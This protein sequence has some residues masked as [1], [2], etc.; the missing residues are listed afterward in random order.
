VIGAIILGM[1]NNAQNAIKD[2]AAKEK[3]VT[4]TLALADSPQ[5]RV[6]DVEDLDTKS[7]F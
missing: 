5:K 4:F 7:M 2:I 1:I 3:D 6:S